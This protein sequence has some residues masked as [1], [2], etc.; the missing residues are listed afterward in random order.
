[1]LVVGNRPGW[2]KMRDLHRTLLSARYEQFG[3]RSGQVC[4][5]FL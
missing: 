1:M 3:A 5:K 4:T 2:V